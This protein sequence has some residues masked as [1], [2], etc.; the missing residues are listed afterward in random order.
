MRK[1][2]FSILISFSCLPLDEKL[3]NKAYNVEYTC[4]HS[5]QLIYPSYACS[6]TLIVTDGEAM[7]KNIADLIKNTELGT[8]SDIDSVLH[9]AAVPYYKNSGLQPINF[10]SIQNPIQ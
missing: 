9:L 4:Y 5:G 7:T 6:D 1:I 10:D 3:D 8:D 2:I